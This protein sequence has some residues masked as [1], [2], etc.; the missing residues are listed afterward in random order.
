MFNASDYILDN[1]CRK[2]AAHYPTLYLIPEWAQLEE[3]L[4]IELPVKK[5]RR[6][7]IIFWLLFAGLLTGASYIVLTGHISE[8][9]NNET[10][11][12]ILPNSNSKTKSVP[13]GITN[14]I[15]GQSIHHDSSTKNLT[16]IDKA[17]NIITDKSLIK[18]LTDSKNDNELITTTANKKNL[19]VHEET[20]IEQKRNEQNRQTFFRVKKSDTIEKS[21][22]TET[23]LN[24]I[25]AGTFSMEDK[26][27]DY[28]G[29]YTNTAINIK[30]RNS[31][32]LASKFIDSNA[33]SD[34]KI[35]R[36]KTVKKNSSRFSITALSGTNLN[37]VQFNNPSRAGLDFGILAGYRISPKF[38]VRTGLIF[39]KKYF[40]AT[41]ENISFDSAKLNLP[42]Y[43]TINLEDA[44]GYC[45]FMEVPVMLYYQFSSKR[46]I[47]FYAAGGFSINKMRMESVHYTFLADG[48]TIVE[49]N[50][51]SARHN[52]SDFSTSVTSN[53][54]FGLKYNLNKR[55][56]ISAEPYLKLPLTRFNNNNLRFSTFGTMVLVTYT[57]PAQKKK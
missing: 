52:K 15:P 27:S 53:F 3:K 51:T 23:K 29:V 24:S 31:I 6:R 21:N 2:A 35:A 1:K 39:S 38:E 46:K 41:G 14:A 7:L 36:E 44:T 42:S 5:K 8:I 54:S 49:R 10:A 4:D 11:H 47:N 37:T 28:N 50:H 26:V 40:T 32:A 9:K 33:I 55:W 57:L 18:K 34:N 19:P 20:V 12:V 17:K 43:N 48:N 30:I 25:T 56:N 22:Q 45:R 16:Q 13:W